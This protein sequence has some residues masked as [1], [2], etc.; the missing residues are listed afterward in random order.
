MHSEQILS[1]NFYE[2]VISDNRNAVEEI[3]S[4]SEILQIEIP[5]RIITGMLIIAVEKKLLES[6]KAILAHNMH[7]HNK[8]LDSHLNSIL[9]LAS[10]LNI[11]KD[12]QIT[13]H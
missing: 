8:I 11:L 12:L 3:F 6:I 13:F 4:N 7:S 5:V 2:A 10:R 9:C 1:L